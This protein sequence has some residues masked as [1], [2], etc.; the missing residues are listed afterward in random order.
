M[1]CLW[2]AYYLS[3]CSLSLSFMCCTSVILYVNVRWIASIACM[4][5]AFHGFQSY[6]QHSRRGTTTDFKSVSLR[7]LFR[8]WNTPN[9]HPNL[10]LAF[11]TVFLISKV[12][13]AVLLI[14]M[15]RSLTCS[16]LSMFEASYDKIC[17]LLQILFPVISISQKFK[18]VGIEL[19]IIC[20]CPFVELLY[21]LL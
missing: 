9:T 10:F 6:Q 20:I 12:K 1:R 17:R 8:D 14:I 13:V 3:S 19:H 7:E 16:L 4:S 21:I 5:F 11:L 2:R 18:L 15:P